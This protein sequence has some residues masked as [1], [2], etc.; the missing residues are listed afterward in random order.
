[1]CASTNNNN[2]KGVG[3]ELMVEHSAKTL[4]CEEKPTTNHHQPTNHHHIQ[5]QTKLLVSQPRSDWQSLSDWLRNPRRLICYLYD[6]LCRNSPL[7]MSFESKIW[8]HCAGE[9][10]DMAGSEVSFN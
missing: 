8:A 7:S 5:S 3:G 9:Y 10:N 1:M 2:Q 4:A 6:T